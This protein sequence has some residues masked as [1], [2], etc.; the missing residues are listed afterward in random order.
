MN[1]NTMNT[2]H[3]VLT[4]ADTIEIF[5]NFVFEKM[6]EIFDAFLRARA[7]GTVAESTLLSEIDRRTPLYLMLIDGNTREID[8]AAPSVGMWFGEFEAMRRA[9]NRRLEAVR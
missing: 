3:A 5:S 7:G 1:T 2:E 8:L 9:K 6:T 4:D